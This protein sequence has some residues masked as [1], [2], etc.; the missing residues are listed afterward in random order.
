MRAR[1]DDDLRTLFG[2]WLTENSPGL[3]TFSDD[4]RILVTSFLLH[5]INRALEDE[6]NNGASRV[7]RNAKFVRVL[8]RMC[9]ECKSVSELI[10]RLVESLQEV[11]NVSLVASLQAQ[12]VVGRATKSAR[13][14]PINYVE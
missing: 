9:E 7:D 14:E 6:I 10:A 1:D 5:W 2:E 13:V 8:M 3:T 12:C 11:K 4:E